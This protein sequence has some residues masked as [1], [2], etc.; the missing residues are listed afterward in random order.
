MKFG[1]S[2]AGSD[3]LICVLL[4][5]PRHLLMSSRSGPCLLKYVHSLPR[6]DP[7]P[8]MRALADV[9]SLKAESGENDIWVAQILS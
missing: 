6:E 9:S 8:L 5:V 4:P 3:R 7:L 1:K 2:E